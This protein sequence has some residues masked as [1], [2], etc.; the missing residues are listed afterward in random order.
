M[1]TMYFINPTA[2]KGGVLNPTAN[3][4][5]T[6]HCNMAAIILVKPCELT[7]KG[8]NRKSFE[9]ILRRNLKAMLRSLSLH[10]RLE[11]RPGRIYIHC[12]NEEE[13]EQAEEA[14]SRLMGISGWARVQKT[15]KTIDEVLAAC[16]AE[17]KKLFN[18]GRRSYKIEARRTDK[19]FPVDSHEICC[20]AGDAIRM[21]VPELQV[22]VK[23][24]QGIISVEIRE[25][26]YI[27]GPGKKG[28][29]GLPAGSAGRGLLLLS[30]G[31]DSPVAGCLMAGRGMGLDA[32]YFHTPPYT[33]NEALDKTIT[34]AEIVGSYSMGI[35][36]Y[37]LNFT[38][39]QK[40]IA[41]KS[42][43]EWNTVLL[44]MAMI[45]AASLIAQK[46]KAKCLVTG[47]S[48]SQVASQ[49]IENI[50]CTESRS[51]LPVLRPLIGMDKETIISLAKNFGSYETSILPHADCCVLFSPP[52]PVLRGNVNE[53]TALYDALEITNQLFD[54]AKTAEVKK[55]GYQM[56]V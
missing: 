21:E 23:N 32:V 11:S 24:P 25:N 6:I 19:S 51:R 10:Y 28:R 39:V 7:L 3:K 14:L 1:D 27:Y 33:S 41:E 42:P 15:G 20:T 38:Q 8:G 4:H 36:L 40:T 22:D 16:V 49:T 9:L 13:A 18:S 52:H 17:G 45:D 46:T 34:L 26:A 5:I 50:T 56:P 54:A 2:L 37:I 47:E 44:R 30:G 31:I 29:R 53:A 12:K 35:H 43:P 48:L 55:C